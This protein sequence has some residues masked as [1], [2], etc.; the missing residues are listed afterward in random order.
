MIFYCFDKVIENKIENKIVKK[1]KGE[2]KPK[3]KHFEIKTVNWITN[4]KKEKT[5][6]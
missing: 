5:S 6:T 4:K 2:I 1:K 3:L